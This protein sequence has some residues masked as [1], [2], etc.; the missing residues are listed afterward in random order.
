MVKLKPC[1]FCGGKA[2]LKTFTMGTF[3]KRKFVYVECCVCGNR[4]YVDREPDS[5]EEAWNRR[6][7]DGK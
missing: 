7:E 1:P 5:V 4:T 3:K 2:K 6:A